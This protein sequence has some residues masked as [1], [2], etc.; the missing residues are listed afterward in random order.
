MSYRL[1]FALLGWMCL[2][3]GCS[4]CSFCSTS[5]GNEPTQPQKKETKKMEKDSPGKDAK[6][7]KSDAEWKKILTPEQYRVTRKKGTEKPFTG[8]YWNTKTAGVYRCVCCG[9]PLFESDTKF[10]AGCGWPSFYQP[11]D[12]NNIQESIDKSLNMVRVEVVCKHCGAHLGHVFT[13]GPQPTGLRYCINS[14]SLKLEPKGEKEK[15][16][17]KTAEKEKK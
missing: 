16:K 1:W 8:Q 13:D 14:A 7:Q 4:E 15:E 6:G 11:I 10:D 2:M 5:D 3:V 12:K 17:P 9:A